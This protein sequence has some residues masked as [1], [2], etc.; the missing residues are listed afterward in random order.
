MSRK[1]HGEA[2]KSRSRKRLTEA[3]ERLFRGGDSVREQCDGTRAGV[4]GEEL[5]RRSVP[6]ESHCLNADA[7][8][9]PA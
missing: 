7:G 4:R 3:K 6:G 5:K 8:L 2:D 9:D 1:V